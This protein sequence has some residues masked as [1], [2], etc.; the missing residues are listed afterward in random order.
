MKLK[1]WLNIRVQISPFP[2]KEIFN[3]FDIII[4]VSDEFN[5]SH[6]IEAMK[7]Q[8]EYYWFPMNEFGNDMGLNS[9]YA[10]LTTLYRAELEDKKVLLHCHGGINRSQTVMD[11]YYFMRTGKHRPAI[12]ISKEVEKMFAEYASTEENRKNCLQNNCDHGR[13]PAIRKMELSK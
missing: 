10:S 11:A 9:I 12:K 8:K 13:L 5:H 7:L 1:D 3:E 4:N 6:L 2:N